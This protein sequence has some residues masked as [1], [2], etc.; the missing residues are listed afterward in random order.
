ML[1]LLGRLF[2]SNPLD[3]AV[4]EP[5]RCSFV[6]LI[7]LPIWFVGYPKSVGLE[8]AKFHLNS[9]DV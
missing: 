7:D 8:T 3:N 9:L 6:S 2:D 5:R 4:F 1:E